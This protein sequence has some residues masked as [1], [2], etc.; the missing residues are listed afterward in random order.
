VDSHTTVVIPFDFC[1][2]FVRSL[3]CAEFSSRLSEVAQAFD[4]I[5]ATQF[6]LADGRGLRKA[7]SLGTI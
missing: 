1:V 3:D 5:A 6:L 7:W 2:I 4:A